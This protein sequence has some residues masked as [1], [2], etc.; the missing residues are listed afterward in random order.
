MPKDAK[1]EERQRVAAL[2]KLTHRYSV[3]KFAK[4]LEYASPL[5]LW[6]NPIE[7]ALRFLF[8]VNWRVWRFSSISIPP[9]QIARAFRFLPEDA[10]GPGQTLELG[11]SSCFG[12]ARQLC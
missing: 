5:P 2:Q 1:V 4:R 8:S 7:E 9:W 3:L 11:D 10:G 12:F 6:Y